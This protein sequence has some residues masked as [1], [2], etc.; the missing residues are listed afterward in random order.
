MK[1]TTKGQ[2]AIAALTYIK[3][4]NK[5]GVTRPIPVYEIAKDE[6]ISRHYLEQIFNRLRNAGLIKAVRGPSG[7][8]VITAGHITYKNILDAV[9]EPVNLNS[10]IVTGSSHSA[11]AFA[12]L[13]HVSKQLVESFSAMS[14]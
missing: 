3:E 14:I 5:A 9:D 6:G 1:L 7:G 2:Y 12:N 13:E 11:I 4:K 8:Y 10:N